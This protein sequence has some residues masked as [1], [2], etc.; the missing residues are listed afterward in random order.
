VTL[1]LSVYN[2]FHNVHSSP[3]VLR[4]PPPRSA[5]VS[6]HL[7]LIQPCNTGLLLFEPCNRYMRLVVHDIHNSIHSDERLIIQQEL[8]LLSERLVIRDWALPDQANIACLSSSLCLSLALA[9]SFCGSSVVGTSGRT[10]VTCASRAS[11]S[12][13]T[14]SSSWLD[15]RPPSISLISC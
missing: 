5:S 10:P 15:I 3:N 8:A 14:S 2:V 1:G 12:S 9:R 7:G 4:A 11:S 6:E 13:S